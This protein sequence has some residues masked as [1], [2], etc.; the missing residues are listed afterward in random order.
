MRTDNC[1]L[2]MKLPFSF[3]K[4]QEP[5]EYFLA[6]LL[7][8][9][10][11]S[12][13]VLE[14]KN[15]KLTVVTQQTKELSKP[16]EDSDQEELL[17]ALDKAITTVESQ[18]PNGASLHKTVFGL[19]ETW[20]EETHIKKDY[21]AKLKVISEEL[22][23][24]PIGFL[25]FSEAISHLLQEEEGAPISAILVEAGKHTTTTALIR[26]GKVT[27][28]H[29]APNEHSVAKVV[30]T[31]LAG[32]TSVEILPSRILLF[33]SEDSGKAAQHLL[34]HT[35]SKDL[36]FLHVPQV[37]VL[38]PGFDIKAVLHGTAAQLGFTADENYTHVSTIETPEKKETV[39]TKEMEQ[40]PEEEKTI[41]TDNFTAAD[42]GFAAEQDIAETMPNEKASGNQE[43][44]H[45]TLDAVI[46]EI[47]EEVKERETGEIDHKE[48]LAGDGML[49]TKGIKSAFKNIFSK[50]K[51]KAYVLPEVKDPE[52]EPIK[53]SKRHLSKAVIIFPLLALLFVGGVIFYIFKEKAIVT[54]TVSSKIDS[55]SE[56]VVFAADKGN[57]FDDN[58][59]S[60]STTTLSED[61]TLQGTATGKKSIGDKAKGTVTIYNPDDGD[62]TIAA[63]TTIT[64]SNGLKFTTDK[65]ADI[66][67]ASGDIFSGTKPGTADVS[68]TA[69]DIGTD[70]NLPSGTKFAVGSSTTVAAKNASAFSGGTK[71]D[72]T[73]VSKTDESNLLAQL[74][75]NLQQKAQ[76]DMNNQA[77]GDKVL[78]PVFI[79][80]DVTKKSFD[81]NVG[82][83]ATSI[84]ASE[85]IAF[86][87]IAYA[88]QDV[89]DFAQNAIKNKVSQDLQ[90]ANNGITAD[91]SDAKQKNDTQISATV[92]INAKLYPKLDTKQLTATIKGEDFEKATNFLNNQTQVSHVEIT[93]HPNIPFL[94][95][96]LPRS[97]NNITIV[98]NNE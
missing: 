95:K 57:G 42:F 15:T 76:T 33:S 7:R 81:K 30:E 46:G 22:E 1:E 8:D 83:Q 31:I 77:N 91:V 86:Q 43:I 4:K 13:V 80:S 66:A 32:I 47:P 74:T 97:E 10:T 38:A 51:K 73:V 9:E 11:V 64:S 82:D 59:I 60:G 56:S 37:T 94:P 19:K 87:G 89:Q 79:S 65:D 67:S 88:K 36:P 53:K 16:L 45:G 52:P 92:K 50:K 5:I 6:L 39:V 68:V 29:S 96:M 24:K 98:V 84:T 28:T 20:V 55:Q 18:L 25:V 69:S 85:S 44:K 70:Y 71:K 27:E 93:L 17:D 49:L 41:A 58:Q 40:T 12:V 63:G 26:G 23:L 78:L 35:W 2:I 34:S 14:E 75:K 48:S 90:L 3:G 72:V 61:G 62:K 21:L 54:I